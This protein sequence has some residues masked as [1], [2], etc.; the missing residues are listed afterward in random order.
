MRF[1]L[2]SLAGASKIG[3]PPKLVRKAKEVGLH[4]NRPLPVIPG[5]AFPL[6]MI[7]A[8]SMEDRLIE[9]GQRTG[10]LFWT[11]MP[12]DPAIPP[13]ISDSATDAIPRMDARIASFFNTQ[14]TEDIENRRSAPYLLFDS[15]VTPQG[16][17]ELIRDPIARS[18][19]SIV[20]GVESRNLIIK[21]QSN[22][23][24]L[25]KFLM[26]L[27]LDYWFIRYVT[28]IDPTITPRVYFL[29][30]PVKLPPFRVPKTA[31]AMSEEEY[32]KCAAH[33]RSKV[34]YMVMDR[35]EV[36]VFDLIKTEGVGRES[37]F[38][39][40]LEM[41]MTIIRKLKTLHAH[42]IVHADIH[43]GNIVILHSEDEEFGLIDFGKSFFDSDQKSATDW[44]DPH[45]YLSHF[46]LQGHRLAFRDDVYKTLLAAAFLM[47]EKSTV[48]DVCVELG[49]SKK[50]DELIEL[51]SSKFIFDPPDGDVVEIAF[52]SLG[53]EQRSIVRDSL[54]TAL[55]LARSVAD[56]REL[57]N[58]DA[59]L[60]HLEVA[61]RTARADT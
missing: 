33:P 37:R 53:P 2:I 55:E 42:E 54:S 59:I 57:P 27:Q 46:N 45:C 39:Q 19:D 44:W 16:Q 26:D 10:R 50:R 9:E 21:Y 20:F 40:S 32:V 22:C 29:S 23:R 12:L 25:K 35:A 43:P 15:E 3:S 28:S 34:R 31:F 1:A 7:G 38:F 4:V 47:N 13:Q 17:L 41:G 60:D 56:V 30:P 36:S 52:P 49:N 48:Y 24:T 8:Q 61:L 11:V 58:H 5:L 51:H 18:V 6:A 14:Q